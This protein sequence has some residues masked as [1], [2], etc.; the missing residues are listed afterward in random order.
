MHERHLPKNVV[1]ELLSLP[2]EITESSLQVM[3]EDSSNKPNI[4]H[5]KRTLTDLGRL[6][7][8]LMSFN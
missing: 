6:L 1:Q 7:V 2:S 4:S 5:N 8:I 3:V